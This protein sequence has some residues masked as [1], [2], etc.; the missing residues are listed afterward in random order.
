MQPLGSDQSLRP[1]VGR[2]LAAWDRALAVVFRGGTN[3]GAEEHED[4]AVIAEQSFAA[5]AGFAAFLSAVWTRI[6]DAPVLP[7]YER[8]NEISLWHL[9]CAGFVSGAHFS[10]PRV[11]FGC[12][13]STGYFTELQP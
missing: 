8:G 3:D 12:R 11:R 9:G 7:I 13:A 1:G 6:G 10:D 5:V 2:N 4:L